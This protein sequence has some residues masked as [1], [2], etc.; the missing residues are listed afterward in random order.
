MSTRLCDGGDGVDTPEEVLRM[1]NR[2]LV[3]CW[4]RE[5]QRS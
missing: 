5:G 1:C 2:S 3:G 4:T